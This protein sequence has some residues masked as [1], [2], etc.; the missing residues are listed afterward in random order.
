[1]T[2]SFIVIDGKVKGQDFDST[3]G[4][5]GKYAPILLAMVSKLE[6]KS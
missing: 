5:T 4:Q 2:Y 3:G 6:R 1:M